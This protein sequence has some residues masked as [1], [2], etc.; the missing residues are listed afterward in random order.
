[1]VR[2]RTELYTKRRIV[3]GLER[4]YE[5]G[6]DFRNEG[7]SFKHNP[8]FTMLEFYEAYAD[9]QGVAERL[10]APLARVAAATGYA[11]ELDFTPPWRRETLAEAIGERAGV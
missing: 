8:E 2:V 7:L 1:Y 4:V 9:S 5:L 3:D 10:E 11:G 6:K